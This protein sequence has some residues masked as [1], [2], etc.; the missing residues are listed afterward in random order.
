MDSQHV[1]I[2]IIVRESLILLA[3]RRDGDGFADQWEFPGGKLNK[4]ESATE[5]LHRELVEEV[6]IGVRIVGRL[7]PVTHSYET[8][9]VCLHPFVVEIESGV[10]ASLAAKELRWFAADELQSLAF[11]AAN[12]LLVAQLPGILR[13]LGL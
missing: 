5:C 7:A 8:F 13:Q 12:A 6:G 2:G 10:P 3:R 1:A 9:R 11:P 4:D